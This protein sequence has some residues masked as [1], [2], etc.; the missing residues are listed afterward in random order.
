MGIA[1]GRRRDSD[2]KG[3]V[4]ELADRAV[5]RC[6]RVVALIMRRMKL[7]IFR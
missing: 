2:G 1:C 5:G 6:C 4:S 3:M 7:G